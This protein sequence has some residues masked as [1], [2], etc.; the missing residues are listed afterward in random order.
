[1]AS[2][3]YTE[4]QTRTRTHAY[5]LSPS[6]YETRE[7]TWISDS[8]HWPGKGDCTAVWVEGYLMNSLDKG[9]FQTWNCNYGLDRARMRTTHNEAVEHVHP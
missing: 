6:N 7:Q 9:K 2:N 8:E 3:P 1:V 5:D 4:S